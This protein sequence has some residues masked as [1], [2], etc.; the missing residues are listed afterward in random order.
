MPIDEIIDEI[1]ECLSRLRLAREILT[2]RSTNAQATKAPVS[3]R[4]ALRRPTAP[5]LSSKSRVEKDKPRSR[6]A[7]V[8]VEAGTKPQTERKRVDASM[9]VSATEPLSQPA[10]KEPERTMAASG[11][12]NRVPARARSVSIRSVRDRAPKPAAAK[13]EGPKP[14][15]ALAGPVSSRIVVVPAAQLRQ[16]REKATVPEVR[17]PRM[18]GS[19]LTGRLAFEA[20]FKNESDPV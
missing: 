18:P 6:G 2:G 11:P 4:K 15:I 16:E 20:L 9:T 10:V 13:A 5:A 8:P 1:E 7:A 17:R 3:K 19:G 14:A 12:V